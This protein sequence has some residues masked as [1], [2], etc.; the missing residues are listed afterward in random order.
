MTTMG[1]RVRIALFLTALAS[2][3]GARAEAPVAPSSSACGLAAGDATAIAFPNL[4][5]AMKERKRIV[6]VAIGSSVVG[7]SF[8]NGDYYELVEGFLEKTFK[9]LDVVVVQRGVSGELARDAADR[10][11]LEV[12]RSA[13]D[14]VFWQVG[15]ADAMAGL[16]PAE[17]GE[18]VRDTIRW[19]KDHGVDV[20]LIGLHYTPVLRNDAEYQA[21]RAMITQ[22]AREERVLRVRRYEVGETLE[23]LR[24]GKA[25]TATSGEVATRTDGCMAED[26]AR[27]L[28]TGLF[29]RRP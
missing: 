20:V 14:V 24:A 10:I 13:P 8:R 18:T 15:T 7:G 22:V 5:R 26:L 6:A 11:R 21:V 2:A 12:A 9:G 17:I 3:T 27:S 25:D 19:L 4:E 1:R 29:A 16:D 28:A 23:K